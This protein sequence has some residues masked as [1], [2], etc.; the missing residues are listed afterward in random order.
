MGSYFESAKWAKSANDATKLSAIGRT[1]K[2]V[3]H[4]VT[5]GVLSDVQGGKFAHGFAS[6]GF[7]E[8]AGPLTESMPTQMGRGVVHALIGGT[9]S[10][11]SGGSSAMER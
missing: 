3:A 4:G 6:A 11:L 2:I 10:K 8:A 9:A 5:G 1:A 7:S